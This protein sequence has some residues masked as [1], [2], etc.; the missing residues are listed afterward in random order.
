MP[1]KQS[2]RVTIGKRMHGNYASS[3]WMAQVRQAV[4]AITIIS[5]NN[6]LTNARIVVLL[7]VVRCLLRLLLTK[8][9]LYYHP[10]CNRPPTRNL[11][12]FAP[13]VSPS[14]SLFVGPEMRR[15]DENGLSCS[16]WLSLNTQIITNLY[17]PFPSLSLSLSLCLSLSL[18]SLPVASF[19]HSPCAFWFY[20]V[21][22][23][24]IFYWDSW[25]D[26]CQRLVKGVSKYM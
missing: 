16:A 9:K 26:C 21:W 25:V 20:C 22:G 7:P 17:S 1:S 18:V 4:P 24:N 3:R 5:R 23:L 2:F 8:V 11:T 12:P 15:E 13:R 10:I 14:F 19:F 6:K